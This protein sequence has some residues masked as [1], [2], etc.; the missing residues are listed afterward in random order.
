MEKERKIRKPK[1]TLND[2]STSEEGLAKNYTRATFIIRKDILFKIKS[3]AFKEGKSIKYIIN[4]MLIECIKQYEESGVI[5]SNKREVSK[6][7]NSIEDDP[8]VKYYKSLIE[9]NKKQIVMAKTIEGIKFYTLPEAAKILGITPQTLRK[10]IKQGKIKG[11]KLSNYYLITEK[12][13]FEFLKQ[14]E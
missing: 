12:A 8:C 9:K 2:V 10:Y 13:L 3:I 4:K 7:S 11:K 14:F 6:G 1:Q 5:D